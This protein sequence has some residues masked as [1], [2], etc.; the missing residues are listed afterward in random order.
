M[1]SDLKPE[2]TKFGEVARASKQAERKASRGARMY[3]KGTNTKS[4]S[5]KRSKQ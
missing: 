4:F 2:L 1:A 5:V 3:A